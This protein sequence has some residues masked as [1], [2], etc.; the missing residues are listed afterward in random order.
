MVV[1]LLSLLP[2]MTGP[3]NRKNGVL[4]VGMVH[5][6]DTNVN[7]FKKG[8]IC[9][10]QEQFCRSLKIAVILW[11]TLLCFMKRNKN[12]FLYCGS[13][14][15]RPVASCCDF[16]VCWRVST[17]AVHIQKHTDDLKVCRNSFQFPDGRYRSD[18]RCQKSCIKM[19]YILN[20]TENYSKER[21]ES[22][23]ELC[24]T[25]SVKKTQRYA[26]PKIWFLP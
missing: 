2:E 3:H 19:T 10:R 23:Y 12:I 21:P 7:F 11:R 16:V 20:K 17:I 24:Y 25:R 6:L 1:L 4:P 22:R 8:N 18:G 5:C 13:D 26:V 9:G 15:T 14:A